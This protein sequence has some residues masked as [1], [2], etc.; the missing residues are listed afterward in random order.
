MTVR[1]ALTDARQELAEAGIDDAALEAEVL[2]RDLLDTD[3][4]RFY[5]DIDAPLNA[6]Q[7]KRFQCLIERRLTGE[8]TAYIIGRREFYGRDFMVS[9][10]VL[11]P[12]P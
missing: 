1:H 5:L 10:D 12:R 8:P 6:A 3:R 2:L 4:A 9:A 11:V 7:Q